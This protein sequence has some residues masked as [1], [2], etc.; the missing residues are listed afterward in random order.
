M[1]SFLPFPLY[2]WGKPPSPPYDSWPYTGRPPSPWWRRPQTHQE[3]EESTTKQNNLGKET[4][5]DNWRKKT[6]ET[7]KYHTTRVYKNKQ[8]RNKEKTTPTNKPQKYKKQLARCS[9][10]E[11]QEISLNPGERCLNIASL[12][13]D[14]LRNT[15]RM[16]ELLTRLEIQKSAL[17]AC[18]KPT[19]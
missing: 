19:T 17:R 3:M 15:E 18:K 2:R 12:N 11:K 6:S 13:Y 5:Y 10:P 14:D 8:I 16:N 7:T 4:T 9:N 1:Y